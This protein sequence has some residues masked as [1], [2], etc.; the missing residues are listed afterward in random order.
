M[1]SG[2]GTFPK[3]MWKKF[4]QKGR[5]A[6]G[7]IGARPLDSRFEAATAVGILASRRI[8]LRRCAA[9]EMS[10]ASGSS[11]PRKETAV[12]IMSIGWAALGNSASTRSSAG[13]SARF[14]FSSAWKAASCAAFGNSPFHSR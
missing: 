5:E 7:A 4:S 8:A 1:T 6:S 9:S 3:T 11:I 12:R 10:P 14:A 13:V 2:C